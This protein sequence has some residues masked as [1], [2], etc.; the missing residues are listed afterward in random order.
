VADHGLWLRTIGSLTVLGHKLCHPLGK[1]ITDPHLPDVWFT[2]EDC[3]EIYRQVSAGVYEIY[4]CKRRGR[5][6]R[7]GTWYLLQDTHEGAC[8]RLVQASIWDWDGQSL[9]FHS[10]AHTALG[11]IR[12]RAQGSMWEVLQSWENQSL[13][14]SLRIDQENEEWIV[15]GL[16]RGS[17]IIGHDGSYMPHLANNVCS[18]AVVIHCQH[19]GY[20]ADMR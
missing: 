4:Q 20:Y 19:T 8:P 10:A 7:Y 12:P 15:Q 11:H 18:Y 5:Q 2:L 6:T 13:W 3:S 14:S 9:W 17:P 16:M 1:Y